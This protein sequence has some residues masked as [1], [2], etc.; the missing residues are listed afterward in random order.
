MAIN[1]INFSRV[2]NNLQTLS[3]LDS[4]RRNTM[5]LFA[6]QNRMASGNRLNAPS[7]DPVAASRALDLSELLERQDQILANARHADAFLTATDNGMSEVS[8]LLTQAKTIASSM[9]GS[10]VLADERASQAEII[11]SIIDQLISVGNRTYNG[12][13]LFGGKNTTSPPFARQYGGVA[14]VGD[15]TDLGTD[16]GGPENAVINLTGDTLFHMAGGRI[17]GYQNLEPAVRRETRLVDLKGATS[18]GVRCSQ[19]QVLVDGGATAFTVDLTGADTL[20]NV[21]DLINNA[22]QAAGGSGDLA[23]LAGT[24]LR[25]DTG[26]AGAIEVRESGNGTVAADLGILRSDAGGVIAGDNLHARLTGTTP[27]ETLNGGAGVPLGPIRIT[28]GALSAVVDLSTART[29][30]DILNAINTAGV[31]AKAVI[32]GSA[33]G[34]DVINLVSGTEMRVTE[35]GGTTGDALGILSLHATGLLSGLNHGKGVRATAGKPDFRITSMDGTTVDVSVSGAVTVQ[36]VLDAINQAAAA[37]GASIQAVLNPTGA[38]IRINDTSGGG[39]TLSVER[40]NSSF[41]IDDLG[42]NRRANAGENF[43]VGDDVAGVRADSVFSA[44]IDL[45]S[46]LRRNDTAAINQAAQELETFAPELARLRGI[47]GARSQ[48]M[49][50]RVA[51]TEDAVQATK[52]LLSEVKD[53]DYTEAVTKFQQAQTALQANLLTAS[54]MLNISLLDFLT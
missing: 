31:G 3:V 29:L 11:S 21:V 19:L 25:L 24:G 6:E 33:T 10:V 52:A 46:G 8:D 53:L 34:I 48:A 47:V 5:A 39:G 1:T 30:Q 54:R 20:G 22:W 36:D 42:L 12:V 45:E 37:A 50:N 40:L 35:Q 17:A 15:T 43:L 44:L 27:V 49:H 2:S 16:I 26:G 14:Y 9:V 7:E 18:L 38:G 4:L 13:Y 23:S 32:N 28:N 41:A 51:F